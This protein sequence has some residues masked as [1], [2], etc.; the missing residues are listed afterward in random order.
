MSGTKSLQLSPLA[1]YTTTMANIPLF[2]KRGLGK[3]TI[4][5]DEDVELVAGTRWHVNDSGYAV[6]RYKG[7]TTRLHRLINKTPD[8]LF[9]DHKNGNTLDNRKSNLRS[10]TKKENAQNNHVAKG[11]TWD[12]S[13]QKW[14]VRYRGTYYG[15]YATEREAQQA[16]KLA[17]SGV[18]KQSRV[19]PRRALLPRGVLYM[20]PNARAGRAPYYIRPQRNGKKYFRGYFSTPQEAEAAYNNFLVEED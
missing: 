12:E 18:A 10:V 16:Y 9:T 14:M 13:K 19:H 15:R 5:D 3:F 4:V 20:E 11:Y 6:N 2:G 7:K 1:W 8:G 17:C